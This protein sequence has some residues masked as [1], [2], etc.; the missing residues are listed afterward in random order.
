MAGSADSLLVRRQARTA[1]RRGVGRDGRRPWKVHGSWGVFYDIF[2]LAMPQSA[3]GGLNSLATSFKL[4]TYDWP[5]LVSSPGCPPACPGGEAHPARSATRAFSQHRSRRSQPMRMQEATVGVEHQLSPHV[6]IAAR[7]VHKQLDKPWRTSG[8]SM[9][10]GN[11]IY[12]IGNP[13]Y[14]RATIAFPGV[15]YPKAVRDYD[16]VEVVAR[17]LL[18]RQLGAHRQ[19]RVEPAVRQLL[20]GCPNPTR[21]GAPSRTSAAFDAPSRCSARPATGV[22]PVGHRSSPPGENATDLHGACG[23]SLGV[24]Q[25]VASGVPVSRFATV[26]SRLG[27]SLTSASLRCS[28]WA[29]WQ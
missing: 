21:T 9:R 23:V 27:T 25:S 24:F 17:K 13:G 8:R 20:S 10:P 16:A 22:R 26:T 6:A 2:K 18:D 3:F 7:Y 29:G 14:G 28:T 12:I 11:S 4:E 15:A 1:R 19:L 5:S